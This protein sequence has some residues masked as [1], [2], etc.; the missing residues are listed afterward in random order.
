MSDIIISTKGLEKKFNDIFY[1]LN[2][3]NLKIQKGDM[4]VLL[5]PSGAGKS[6]L[7]RCLNGLEQP[8]KGEIFFNGK[9]I[10]T[11]K[12]LRN[13]RKKTG[14]IFQQ[15]NLV[16]RLTVLQ[17]VLCG[18]L[19]YTSPFLSCLK[20]FSK[21]D[22]DLA[23]F[24]IN[25]V[26]L[27]EKLNDRIDHLSGGQQQRVAIARA[28]VQ[29]PE[30]ILADEPVASLDPIS[31]SEIMDILKDIN[32]KDNITVI[33]SLHNVHLAKKYAKKIIGIREGQIVLQKNNKDL[34]KEDI[35]M[36]YGKD[37]NEKLKVEKNKTVNFDV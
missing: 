10:L 16:K 34:T 17:N 6:T 30:I 36:I 33:I 26:G 25:R 29:E 20:L 5:G 28:L 14:M 37:V 13:I 1:A 27:I 23:K 22:I 3:I 32:K 11:K 18:R 4:T 12:T 35:S 19:A 2:N 31:S 9:T 8:T 24:C 7:L 15:F 21:N